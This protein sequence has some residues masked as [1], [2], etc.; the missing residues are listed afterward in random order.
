M[1]IVECQLGDGTTPKGELPVLRLGAPLDFNLAEDEVKRVPLGVT[2]NVPVLLLECDY[3]R[4]Q[5]LELVNKATL[6]LPG[7]EVE[8]HVKCLAA[9]IP[10]DR[11]STVA[12]VV[13]LT[14]NQD[15]F[16]I[17]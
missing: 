16:T 7:Q 11:G 2:F 3:A 1:A 12:V 10:I 6:V 8:A 17:V 9:S 5:G 4:S 13:A 15:V 14:S